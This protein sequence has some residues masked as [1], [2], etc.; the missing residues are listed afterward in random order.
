MR[1]GTIPLPLISGM[2]ESAKLPTS[3][4]VVFEQMLNGIEVIGK[5]L[6]RLPNT[7]CIAC[8]NKT[9]V[10]MALDMNGI[11]VSS[12]AACVDGAS[13]R[14]QSVFAMGL[15]V[16]TLRISCGWSTTLEEYQKCA[17]ILNKFVQTY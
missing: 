5:N 3:T 14:A 6:P 9:E 16:D 10:L 2:V 15:D 12:G 11:M 8:R 13:D 17:E 4:N 1:Q 7:T